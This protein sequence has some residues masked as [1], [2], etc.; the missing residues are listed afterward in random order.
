MTETKP[1]SKW[2]DYVVI[3]GPRIFVGLV[4]VVSGIG[5]TPG[6]TE[7]VD[8]LLGSFWSPTMAYLIGH[9]LP[10]AEL[11][12]GLVLLGGIYPRIASAL[13]IPITIGFMTSNCWAL[14]QGV[15]EFSTCGYCLGIFEDLFGALSPLQALLVDILLL[16]FAIIILLYH[17]GRF[18]DF[19]PS[20]LE[21]NELLLGTVA[22]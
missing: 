5:K 13:C 9:C 20:L 21:K 16:C 15:A 4:F 1:R 7:F 8:V 6:Q 12:L 18:Q 19:R 3:L 17:P 22:R 14:S 2:Q 11:V 10:W